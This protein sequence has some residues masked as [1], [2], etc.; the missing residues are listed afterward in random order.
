MFKSSLFL[1]IFA[2][3]SQALATTI[4]SGETID[5]LEKNSALIAIG[6]AE[7]PKYTPLSS[8]ETEY[9]MMAQPSKNST[10][11]TLPRQSRNVGQGV[12]GM[13]RAHR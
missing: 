6:T 5:V 10:I 13:A 2:L 12:S 1:L 11:V 7:K 8:L 3:T 9:A 4:K